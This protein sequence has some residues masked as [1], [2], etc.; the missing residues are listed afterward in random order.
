MPEMEGLSTR[1][2]IAAKRKALTR[3]RKDADQARLM[4]VAPDLEF[5]PATIATS[6]TPGKFENLGSIRLRWAEPDLFEFIPRKSKP[7]AFIRHTGERVEPRNMITDGG[8]IPKVAQVKTSL[9]PWGYAP[10]Y[11]LHDWEFEA[12]HC[13][14]T[15]KS[16]EEVTLTCMEAIQT[17]MRDKVVP[18]DWLDLAAIHLA[19]SSFIARSYWD[20]DPPACTLPKDQ[21]D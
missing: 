5:A 20:R 21:P 10:A 12:H 3:L 14:K 1:A 16:F 11:L 7:F 15:A 13:G 19:I 2:A 9:S 17:L 18:N 4:G 8:S 6:F